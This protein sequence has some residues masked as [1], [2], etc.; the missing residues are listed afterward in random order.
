MLKQGKLRLCIKLCLLPRPFIG[1]LGEKLLQ[2][3]TPMKII[4]DTRD[5]NDDELVERRVCG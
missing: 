4:N 5:A 3:N 2:R 1:A